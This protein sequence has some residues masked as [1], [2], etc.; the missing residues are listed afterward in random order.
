MDRYNIVLGFLNDTAENVDVWMAKAPAKERFFPAAFPDNAADKVSSKVAELRR[1]E[2]V[3]S[4]KGIGEIGPQYEGLAPNAPTL[5]PYFSL[6]EELDLP[7]LIHTAGLGAHVPSYRASNGH[8]LF[9][10]DVIVA[11]PKLRL[12]VENAGY[13]F[14]DEIIALMTQHEGIYADVSTITWIIPRTAFHRYLRG[15]IDAGLGKRIMFGSDQ[16]EWP[17][18][19]GLAVESIQLADFLTADQ[20]RDIFYNNAARFLR[21]ENKSR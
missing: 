1:R 16:M 8:P 11:H 15:L 10:E 13:P 18:T 4:I 5:A 12:Y 14:L 2:A 19:I 9:L 7:V 20:R 17:E 6:A 21:L 3:G